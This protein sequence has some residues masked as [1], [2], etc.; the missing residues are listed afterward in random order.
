MKNIRIW[1]VL[2]LIL[3]AG[4]GFTR[5]TS[6]Y[7]SRHQSSTSIGKPEPTEADTTSRYLTRLEEIEQE[8]EQKR[9][10]EK[11][12]AAG[13][14]TAKTRTENEWRLWQAE[15][16]RVLELLGKQLDDEE[17]NS[18]FQEQRDWVRDR[19]TR[20]IAASTKQSGAILE[21]VEYNRSLGMETRTRVYELVERY[22]D[23]LQ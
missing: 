14:S 8:I 10:R 2:I 3:I 13:H 1:I 5:Y 16:D 9:N 6:Q 19:E 7:V 21:E 23:L 20:A 18:L 4:I 15:M 22:E 12:A 17:R 11:D